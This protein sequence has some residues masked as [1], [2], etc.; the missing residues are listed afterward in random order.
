[1]KENTYLRAYLEEQ[2]ANQKV[3]PVKPKIS[4]KEI[5][6]PEETPK[7]VFPEIEKPEEIEGQMEIKEVVQDSL[8]KSPKEGLVV[9]SAK[10]KK[11]ESK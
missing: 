2:A 11:K 9:K 7:T 5:K 4:K 8:T 10:K 1:M 6:M 3:A